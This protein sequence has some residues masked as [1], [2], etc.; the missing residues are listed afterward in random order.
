MNNPTSSR[1][2]TFLVIAGSSVLFCS[3]GVFAKLAYTHGI[4]ALTVLMLRMSM[5]FPFFAAFAIVPTPGKP[6]LEA[7]DWLRL[8]G[9]GFVGYYLSSLVNFSGLQYIS[10]GL[11]RIILYT[12]PSLVLA[13]S[14]LIFR[15]SVR[16]VI[17]TACAVTW[18]GIVSAFAGE[19]HSPVAN[20]RTLLG[21]VLIFGSALSYAT[22]IMI[23]GDTITRVGARRFA[24]IVV[25][26]SCL[27]MMIHFLLTHPVSALGNLPA[28]VYGYGAVLAVFGTV[29][30]A[31]LQSIGLQ[32]A[33][34]QTFAVISTIGPVATLFVAWAFL[35]EKPNLAQALGF[36]LTVSGGLAVSLLKGPA[37]S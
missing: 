34:A 2:A 3:K 30:P 4:D 18:V 28:P 29:A 33:G 19:A 12:Y 37:R 15:R 25:G 27:F 31:L 8:A 9:L 32:R 21:A 7:R 17:W 6:P 13:I 11:E 26:F 36:A 14:A 22:F 23:S 5:A 20:D 24:G 16:P 1:I 10:V 35:G